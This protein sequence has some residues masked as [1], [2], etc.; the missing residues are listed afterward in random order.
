MPELPDVETFLNYFREHALGKEITDVKVFERKT[1]RNSNENELQK[2]LLHDSF[3]SVERYGKWLIIKTQK[4]NYLAMHFGMTGYLE[5]TKKDKISRSTRLSFELNGAKLLFVDQR[6]FGG[7]EIIK[8]KK[9]LIKKHELG[10]DALNIEWTGFKKL[11]REKRGSVKQ[12]LMDQSVISGIGNIYTDEILF[13]AAIH[14]NSLTSHLTDKQLKML[15]TKMQ[16]VLKSSIKHH[17][18]PEEFP[19]NYLTPHRR[20]GESWP[21][22]HGEVQT[23]KVGGRTTYFCPAVQTKY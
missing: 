11:F 2:L 9:E 18:N 1:L 23:L 3:K 17:A 5:F 19:K 20:K 8:N 15:F 10:I 13:Q 12:I 14:P 4:G 6:K 7:I 16:M 21:A 22:C